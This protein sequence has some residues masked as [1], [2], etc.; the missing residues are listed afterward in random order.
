M[1]D[2]GYGTDIA[3]VSY[4]FQAHPHF[5]PAQLRGAHHTHLRDATQIL[6]STVVPRPIA[7]VSTLSAENIPNLAP[8]RYGMRLVLFIFRSD[9]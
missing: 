8:F 1:E 6:N 4:P 7:F 9:S 3:C 2:L 5:T